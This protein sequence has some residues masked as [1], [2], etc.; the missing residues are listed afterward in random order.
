M[1][2]PRA[3]GLVWTIPTPSSHTIPPPSHRRHATGIGSSGARCGRTAAPANSQG[4]DC[5][6]PAHS[7]APSHTQYTPARTH[8]NGYCTAI[9]LYGRMNGW[10]GSM[11]YMHM[12]PPSFFCFF[13][14]FFCAP[15]T[16]A[17][18]P[19]P[20]CRLPV[21]VGQLL[22]ASCCWPLLLLLLKK[23]YILIRTPLA[24]HRGTTSFFHGPFPPFTATVLPVRPVLH[25][26]FGVQCRGYT[27]RVHLAIP[28]HSYT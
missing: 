28:T 20:H 3:N 17:P 5:I 10:A 1:L 4:R 27:I 18:G 6:S 11:V 26:A 24:V 8:T 12:R 25:H 23:C 9:L 13:L 14:V 16:P 7:L 19:L 21:S 2:Q 15:P 22:L